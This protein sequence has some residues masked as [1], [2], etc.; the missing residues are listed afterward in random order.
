MVVK[1]LRE[2]IEIPTGHSFR[3]IRWSRN[4]K[5]VEVVLGDGSTSKTPGEGSHWH[6]HPEMELTLFKSGQGTRFV[7]HHIG[8][9]DAG[10]LVL[11]GSNLPHYWHVDGKSSGLSVQW[12]F[13]PGHSLWSF[14]ET[15]VAQL[16][17]QHAE[18]GLRLT[19]D[20]GQRVARCLERIFETHGTMRLSTLLELF[21]L[22]LEVS[23]TEVETLSS[24]TF[25]LGGSR[26]QPVIAKAVR[27]LVANFR[28]EVKL[29]DLLK[30]TGMSRPTFAR[31]FK[32]HSGRSFSEFMNGIRLQA[33]CRELL[34]TDRTVLEISL[35][36]GFNQI[37]FFNRLFKREKGCSPSGFRKGCREMRTS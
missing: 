6:H 24:R 37:S 7:G 9:F 16:A 34:E 11:L 12:H 21:A 5:E 20:G 25:G 31:Q 28:E 14:P 3:A 22:L 32:I 19:G 29:E 18:R 10:D 13:P 27:H 2:T 23:E 30:L 4:P 17:F 36:C 33:A 35:D 15:H 1:G 26:Y 8:S